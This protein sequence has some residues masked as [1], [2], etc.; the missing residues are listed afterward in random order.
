MYIAERLILSPG[1][2]Q[3]KSAVDL[4]DMDSDDVLVDINVLNISVISVKASHKDGNRDLDR[5]LG[6]TITETGNDGKVR[7]FRKCTCCW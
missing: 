3:Q 1:N 5:F 4:I 6:E 7:K 2:K